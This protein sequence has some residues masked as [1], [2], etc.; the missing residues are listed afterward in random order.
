MFK[1]RNAAEADHT[2]AMSSQTPLWGLKSCGCGVRFR[3]CTM[4]H[5]PARGAALTGVL[6]DTR[7][8]ETFA[9]NSL[10]TVVSFLLTPDVP[11]SVLF[12][13]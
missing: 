1:V 13:N 6:C 5:E 2:T 4:L 9:A 7:R 10:M 12:T 8:S 3:W 11:A